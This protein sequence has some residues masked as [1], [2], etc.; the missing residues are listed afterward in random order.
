M[1]AAGRILGVC[2][3]WR[4]WCRSGGCDGGGWHGQAG[5]R[6][7]QAGRQRG[8]HRRAAPAA[9][10]SIHPF[11]EG[12][13]RTETVFFHLLCRN[14]GYDLGAERLY[15]RRAEFIAARFH[16]HAVGDRYKRL[17][18][19]LA[20]TVDVRPTLE[21]TARELSWAQRLYQ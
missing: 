17:T 10:D 3:S 18:A 19:L 20:D 8:D 12:N 13:T 9:I 5:A 2:R 7:D 16:G 21:L 15:T 11:R 1:G 4:M 14:A 6:A